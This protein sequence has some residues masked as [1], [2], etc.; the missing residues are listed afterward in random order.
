MANQ[1]QLSEADIASAKERRR[2][3]MALAEIEGN[4]LMLGDIELFELYEREGWSHA[5]RLADLKERAA[6]HLAPKP[7]HGA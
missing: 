2:E 3:A 4:P 7:E 5:R 1:E 6:A